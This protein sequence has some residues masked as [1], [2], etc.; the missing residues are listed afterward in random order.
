MRA[1]SILT[2]IKIPPHILHRNLSAIY[3]TYQLIV[4]LLTYRT[5]DYLAN[6]W[7]KNV[8]TLNSLVILI[9]LHIESLDILRIICH[10][11]RL[12]EMMLYKETLMLA[13]K[14]NTPR[15]RIFKLLTISDS[16]FKNLYTL[17][18]RKAYKVLLQHTFK[19]L[20]KSL[21]N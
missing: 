5:T 13:G 11:N 1:T 15:Y 18:I 12:L 4:V 9:D 21:I 7:E 3:F 19:S 8:S 17:S 6:L 20:D 16:L 2:S 14:V 10:N